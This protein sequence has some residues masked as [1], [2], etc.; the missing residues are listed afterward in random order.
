MQDLGCKLLD[1]KFGILDSR[2]NLHL[3][4]YLQRVSEVVLTRGDLCDPL[5]KVENVNG[6]LV[7]LRRGRAKQLGRVLHEGLVGLGKNKCLWESICLDLASFT[8]SLVPPKC[9]Y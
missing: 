7:S 3:V 6:E 1:S 8:H 9:I 4:V 2:T 5:L